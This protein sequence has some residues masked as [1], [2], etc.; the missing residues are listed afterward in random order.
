MY[1]F[2]TIGW[3]FFFFMVIATA[4]LV[5]LSR[6]K[7]QQGGNLL[8]GS[9]SKGIFSYAMPLLIGSLFEQSYNLVDSIVVGKILGVGAL[10]AV[11]VSGS[12]IWFTASF[13]IGILMGVG[14]LIAQFY[15]AKQFDNLQKV[16]NTSFIFFGVCSLAISLLAVIFAKPL[17]QLFDTPIEVIDLATSYYAITMA[18]MILF[19]I[20][21]VANTVMQSTGDSTTPFLFLALATILNI[22]LDILFVAVLGYGIEGAAW[23][24]LISRFVS[25]T[26]CLIV[27]SR[28]SNPYLKLSL[29]KM[30]FHFD[31]ALRSLKLGIPTAIQ[32]TTQSLGFLM[33]IRLINSFGASALAAYGVVSRIDGLLLLP[34]YN[35][36]AAIATF[37]GQNLGAGDQKR[38]KEGVW[39]A[40]VM[41]LGFTLV[42]CLPSF[43]LRSNLITIFI[44]EDELETIH[45]GAEYFRVAMWG[46][47]FTALTFLLSGAIRGAGK[48][49][50]SLVISLASL[51][52]VRLPVAYL[53]AKTSLG[54]NGVW[55]SS[56]IHWSVATLMAVLYF[57]FGKWQNTKLVD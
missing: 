14:T 28:H 35:F 4:F 52:A 7:L 44:N 43:F 25:M 22:V 9:I 19:A 48:P 11:N 39:R 27:L 29:T 17:L 24:T 49:M 38:A 55:L 23:A 42:L 6:K 2:F 36:S 33:Q 54:L 8:Q 26:G 5:F 41:S 37:I 56:A 20:S 10:A 1:N 13:F 18:G 40:M 50:V 46:Y 34:A 15:G 31:M 47:P 51:W 45:F 3:F 21:W 12:L 16:I 30:A 53:L 57:Y 32:Q